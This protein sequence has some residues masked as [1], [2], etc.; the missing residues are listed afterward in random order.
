MK[1]KKPKKKVSW[2][3]KDMEMEPMSAT[4]GLG[5]EHSVSMLGQLIAT[6]EEIIKAFQAKYE[7]SPDEIEIVQTNKKGIYR[8]YVQK[9]KK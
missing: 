6:Q 9:K 4:E 3:K 1:L 2:T 5:K 8:W 7:L